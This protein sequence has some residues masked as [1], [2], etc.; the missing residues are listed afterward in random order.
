MDLLSE[1]PDLV[2]ERYGYF[3]ISGNETLGHY[4]EMCVIDNKNRHLRIKVTECVIYDGWDD[5]NPDITFF[6][7]T[8]LNLLQQYK[9]K[10]WSDEK[11]V[12][13]DRKEDDLDKFIDLVI[14]KYEKGG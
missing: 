8:D 1:I 11:G 7:L 14:K 5:E 12:H 4:I 3:N 10:P 6:E 2:E 13:H 9:S